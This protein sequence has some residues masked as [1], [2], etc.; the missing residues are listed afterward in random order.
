MDLVRDDAIAASVDKGERRP[1]VIG[2]ARRPSGSLGLLGSPWVS[3]SPPGIPEYRSLDSIRIGR[4]SRAMR[5]ARGEARR[6]LA[7]MPAC[8]W[9]RASY[10]CLPIAPILY[11]FTPPA[12]PADPLFPRSMCSNPPLGTKM[13]EARFAGPPMDPWVSISTALTCPTV[14]LPEHFLSLV[15]SP[16]RLD[17]GWQGACLACRAIRLSHRARAVHGTRQEI[18]RSISPDP[19]FPFAIGLIL[20]PPHSEQLGSWTPGS[21]GSRTV[22]HSRLLSNVVSIC[23]PPSPARQRAS[24][25]TIT[26]RPRTLS[27]FVLPNTHYVI[28]PTCAPH[29]SAPPRPVSP[30]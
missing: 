29:P 2:K 17:P 7:R 3:G 6:G 1:A 24:V 23:G 20:S 4:R 18:F 8:T 25:T 5:E 30:G 10:V 21:L 28:P 26:G 22:R 27:R 15:A 16:C 12:P 14:R 9:A 11:S 19:P 13:A